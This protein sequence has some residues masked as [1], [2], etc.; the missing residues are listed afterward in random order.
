MRAAACSFPCRS[1]PQELIYSGAGEFL[2]RDVLIQIARQVAIGI[3][4]RGPVGVSI[5][6]SSSGRQSRLKSV[7]LRTLAN[8]YHLVNRVFEKHTFQAIAGVTRARVLRPR[9][10]H[11]EIRCLFD[12]S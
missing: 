10:C 11:F 2:A 9:L 1:Q 8:R 4:S 12:D 7:P 3:V 5:L 6:N